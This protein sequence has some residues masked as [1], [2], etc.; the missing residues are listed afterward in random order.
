MSKVSSGADSPPCPER[1]PICKGRCFGKSG[2]GFIKTAGKGY[3]HPH[4]CR[5]HIWAT[6]GEWVDIM[7]SEARET[8]REVRETIQGCRKCVAAVERLGGI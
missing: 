3:A 7:R 5:E 2:H 8:R 6:S 4:G 1:C